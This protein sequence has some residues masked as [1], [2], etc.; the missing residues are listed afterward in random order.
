MKNKG[1]IFFALLCAIFTSCKPEP[2]EVNMKQAPVKLCISNLY[3][4]EGV[5]GI[6]VS[7]SFGATEQ[8]VREQNGNL[9]IDT[10]L[11]IPDAQVWLKGPL[12]QL[13]FEEL[14][15]GIYGSPDA[16]LEDGKSY[17]ILV[18][19]PQWG[20]IS[21]RAE[22]M[23]QVFFDSIGLWSK[24][25]ETFVQY[26]FSDVPNEENYYVVNYLIPKVK[27]KIPEK[28]DPDYIA[29][30]LLEQQGSFDLI[31]EKD[32]REGKYSLQKKLPPMAVSDSVI[33][34]LSNISKPYYEFL[35]A[36]K[37]AGTLFNQLR[38]EVVNFPGNINNGYGFFSLHHPDFRLL[39]LPL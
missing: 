21:A 37:R 33:V 5:L 15:R 11:L 22:K 35:Y 14:M 34:S 27:E 31:T 24:N 12:F 19:H 7:R 32:M 28:P 1:Y 29:R 13:P 30:K 20:N 8:V 17:E 4:E 25:N 9:E 39:K 38:G 18:S 36:Q 2:L 26:S 23:K 3:V 16:F 6:S 10:T